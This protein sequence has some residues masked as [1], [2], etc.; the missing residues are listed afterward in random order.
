MVSLFA[1]VVERKCCAVVREGY[2]LGRGA[3]RAATCWPTFVVS[4][5][6]VAMGS[7]DL[8]GLME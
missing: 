2:G 3:E 7:N 4:L 8:S 6:T 5:S 1:S